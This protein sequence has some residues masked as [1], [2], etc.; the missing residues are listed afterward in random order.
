MSVL[1][2]YNRT[3]KGLYFSYTRKD[4][5]L[6]PLLTTQKDHRPISIFV[7]KDDRLDLIHA[8]N[9]RPIPCVS[10]YEFEGGGHGIIKLL[11]DEGK[12]PAIM[13]GNYTE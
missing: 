1:V 9:L 7:S 4:W 11:R 10:I 8:Q 3:K 12:L 5:D 6:Q 2:S 13:A